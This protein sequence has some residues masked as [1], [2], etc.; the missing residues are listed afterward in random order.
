MCVDEGILNLDVIDGLIEF[1]KADYEDKLSK[2][3]VDESY[4]YRILLVNILVDF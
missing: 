1:V 2:Q 4:I 3:I